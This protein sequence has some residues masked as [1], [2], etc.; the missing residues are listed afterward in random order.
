MPHEASVLA[1]ELQRRADRE[2]SPKENGRPTRWWDTGKF[3]CTNDHVGTNVLKTENE[4]DRCL[5]CQAPVFLTFPEDV[6]GPLELTSD[7]VKQEVNTP[8]LADF[9]KASERLGNMFY[10]GN[11]MFY[12]PE[13][14][15]YPDVKLVD[16]FVDSLL[17]AVVAMATNLA[18]RYDGPG[19][20][21]TRPHFWI[22][23]L[24]GE[25]FDADKL[26]A[27]YGVEPTPP[28]V[29]Q[30][31]SVCHEDFDAPAD[32]ATRTITLSP[33]PVCPKCS[34]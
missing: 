22:N 9:R 25:G 18:G 26:I 4:G 31:C 32:T 23:N 34:Q 17:R 12:S 6:D 11:D 30:E 1:E 15:T 5:T 33:N 27:K 10:S 7:K 3:R 8:S 19:S 14:A 16:D 29:T 28:K 20:G 2:D 13:K 21:P 24:L